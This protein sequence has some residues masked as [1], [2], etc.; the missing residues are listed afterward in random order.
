MHSLK[1]QT[2][3]V[4]PHRSMTDTSYTKLNSR[5]K[6]F[7]QSSTPIYKIFQDQTNFQH[8]SGPFEKYGKKFQT[9]KDFPTGVHIR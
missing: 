8:F 5:T 1:A 2:N 6:I 7:T 3:H 9:F 4:C